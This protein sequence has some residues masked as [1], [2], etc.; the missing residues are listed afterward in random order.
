MVSVAEK[1]C[2]RLT[3]VSATTFLTEGEK[4]CERLR[5][6]SLCAT[7]ISGGHQMDA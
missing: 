4:D 6:L 7:T 3:Y 5:T 2:R 1:M